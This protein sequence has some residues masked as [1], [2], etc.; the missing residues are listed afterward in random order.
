MF[1]RAS[2]DA[3][4]PGQQVVDL[5]A[6]AQR[7]PTSEHEADRIFLYVQAYNRMTPQLPAKLVDS[8]APLVGRDPHTWFD[9]TD[10]GP[11][12]ALTVL[13]LVAASA[14]RIPAPTA[15][16][17]RICQKAATELLAYLPEF[18][19]Q[20]TRPSNVNEQVWGKAR[21]EMESAAR[22]ALAVGS[23]SQR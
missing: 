21:A 4:N 7:Y 15:H 5:D 20:P 23:P 19:D 2:S 16:Q 1:E 13:F 6:W 11:A 22:E 17:L 8:A 10:A 9:D 12:Q 18:F 3:D 14:Q